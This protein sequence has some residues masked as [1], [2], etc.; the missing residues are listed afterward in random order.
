MEGFSLVLPGRWEE[1]VE[2]L[3]KIDERDD[4]GLYGT[5]DVT[6]SALPFQNKEDTASGLQNDG[7]AIP[8]CF[9]RNPRKSGF[10]IL[11]ED[12]GEGSPGPR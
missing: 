11:L 6:S 7:Y 5:S 2:L 8:S 9:H 12:A 4:V 3:M 10:A 1:A